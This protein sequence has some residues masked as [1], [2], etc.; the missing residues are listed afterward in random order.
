MPAPLSH[1][2]LEQEGTLTGYHL[3]SYGYQVT[4]IDGKQYFTTFDLRDWPQQARTPVRVR[5]QV[6]EQDPDRKYSPGEIILG[7]PEAHITQYLVE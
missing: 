6:K 1:F 4:T 2:G 5:F 7:G 3:T